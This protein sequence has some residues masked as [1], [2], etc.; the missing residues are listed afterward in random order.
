[1]PAGL[2]LGLAA[3]VKYQALFG[4]LSVA[5]W[6][7]WS[8]VRHRAGQRRVVDREF[9]VR[10]MHHLA[11]GV[12]G[13]SR[14]MKT[15]AATTVLFCVAIAVS[16]PWWGKN[17]WAWRNPFY[18]VISNST[19]EAA[20]SHA[21]PLSQV[22]EFTP[23]QNRSAW[24]LLSD[25]IGIF[26]SPNRY[27]GPP[28]EFPHYLFLA[29][30]LLLVCR[31]NRA[32][33]S[34]LLIALVYY[35]VSI[36]LTDCT[37]YLFPI[38]GI[39][40][41][42]VASV[43]AEFEI[44]WKLR[45]FFPGLLVF[46]LLFV[47]LLPSRIVRLPMLLTYLAGGSDERLLLHDISPGFHAAVDWINENTAAD[48]VILM[49]WDAREY[50]LQRRTIIDPGKVLWPTLFRE[51]RTTAAQVADF[52]HQHGIDY[53]FVNEGALHFNTYNARLIPEQVLHDFQRQR[54]LLVG[55][56]LAPVARHRAVTIY[57]V[58]TE[59]NGCNLRGAHS[60][61]VVCR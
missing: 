32:V 16:S 30:P 50:R 28:N 39:V 8:G 19:P 12:A 2:C 1:L 59:S 51:G 48:A 6:L 15:V 55:P 31:R 21:R 40:S 27:S 11:S 29:L 7:V 33:N 41:I 26:V 9:C 46:L 53:V 23:R 44:R 14:A 57:R 47:F 10:F 49:C 61:G 54:E 17:V 38:F 35:L 45:V 52:L 4:W 13:T 58:L 34:L 22:A 36:S 3:G 56:V 24:Y 18:P 20:A 25:T 5:V 37:R 60:R 42:A 43:I